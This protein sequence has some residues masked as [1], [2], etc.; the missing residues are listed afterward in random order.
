ELTVPSSAE[1]LETEEHWSQKDKIWKT[2]AVAAGDQ[3]MWS[4][5]TVVRQYSVTDLNDD[6]FFDEPLDGATSPGQVHIKELEVLVR[7][8]RSERGAF[9]NVWQTRLRMLKAK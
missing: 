5:T 6:G 7:S 1:E 3:A 4:R 2:G 9:G 8:N